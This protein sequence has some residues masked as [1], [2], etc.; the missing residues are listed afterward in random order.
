MD[1]YRAGMAHK[2]IQQR[3]HALLK[4]AKTKVRT[5]DIVKW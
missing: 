1:R 5:Y 3:I 4:E 2:A